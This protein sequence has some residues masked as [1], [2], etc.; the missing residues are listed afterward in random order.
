MLQIEHRI[1]F[2]RVLSVFCRNIHIAYTRTVFHSRPVTFPADFSARH[3]PVRKV[4]VTSGFRDIYTAGHCRAAIEM[5]AARIGNTLSVN[6]QEII[7]EARFLRVYG[8]GP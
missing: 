5:L 2:Q 4:E 8:H 3:I 6:D 1:A 7:M